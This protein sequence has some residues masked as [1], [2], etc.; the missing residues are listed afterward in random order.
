M[1]SY[2]WER[3]ELFPYASLEGRM[4]Y[5]HSGNAMMANC[6]FT[7]EH[8]IKMICAFD[9]VA[10]AKHLDID[11]RNIFR[12]SRQNN[13]KKFV[14]IEL[15]V[16]D[17]ALSQNDF[18]IRVLRPLFDKLDEVK[19]QSGRPP[20]NP[21]I[22]ALEEHIQ[23]HAKIIEALQTQGRDLEQQCNTLLNIVKGQA[24]K[25]AKMEKWLADVSHGRASYQPLFDHWPG[26]DGR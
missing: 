5:A 25:I 6:I 22:E 24:D 13:F 3:N 12:V 4:G 19:R 20:L 7:N 14:D 23:W 18:E 9:G 15:A 17:R 26:Q 2:S 1:G 8:I 16:T 21:R 11:G 10:S